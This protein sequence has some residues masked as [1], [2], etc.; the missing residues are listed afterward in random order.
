MFIELKKKFK[1]LSWHSKLLLNEQ[2][3]EY[4]NGWIN[5]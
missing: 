1:T 5:K 2:I 4:A 3:D